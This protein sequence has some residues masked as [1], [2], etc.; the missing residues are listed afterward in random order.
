MLITQCW[1]DSMVMMMMMVMEYETD[2]SDG[3]YRSSVSVQCPMNTVN[4]PFNPGIHIGE[5][6]EVSGC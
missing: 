1:Y 6:H 4:L 5:V 3:R 2:V